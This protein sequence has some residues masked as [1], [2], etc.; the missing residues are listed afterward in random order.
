MKAVFY[1][2]KNSATRGSGLTGVHHNNNSSSGG[3]IGGGSTN[4][5]LSTPPEDFAFLDEARIADRPSGGGLGVDMAAW[6]E[7]WDY[8][9]GT[10]FRGFLVEDGGEKSLFAFFDAG[11]VGRDLKQGLM[12]LIELAE[13]ALG[14]S[15]LVI[16]ISRSIPDAESKALMKGLQWA[17]FSIT[18]L[19]FWGGGLD[20]TSKK[21]L[22]MGMEL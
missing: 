14:C 18:G 22:L 4:G 20:V 6:M 17:G 9:G 15:Q 19:D 21:W 16:C 3:A 13:A 7:I 5:Q 1:G 12:A 8:V 2:D 11:V 10:S